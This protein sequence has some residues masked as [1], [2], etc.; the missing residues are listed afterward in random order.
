MPF[1]NVIPYAAAPSAQAEL[2]RIEEEKERKR[3]ELADKTRRPLERA[4]DGRAT[5]GT[6][7]RRS[8]LVAGR[9]MRAAIIISVRVARSA[10][11][12]RRVAGVPLL[13]KRGCGVGSDWPGDLLSGRGMSGALL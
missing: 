3:Q 6:A 12:L 7:L 10:A 9:A 1:R 5:A 13:L 11:R 2:R 8:V 4:A